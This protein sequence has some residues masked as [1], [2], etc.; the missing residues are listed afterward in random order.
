MVSKAKQREADRARRAQRIAARKR[1][2]L[3][4]FCKAPHP[5]ESWA[6]HGRQCSF[7]IVPHRVYR[8]AEAGCPRCGAVHT[9][10]G[11]GWIIST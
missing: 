7:Q 5:S 10:D 9:F 3:G 11:V 2:A 4:F 1:E 6:A 8:G